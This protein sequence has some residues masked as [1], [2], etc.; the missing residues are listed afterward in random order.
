MV[1]VDDDAPEFTAS[2]AHDGIEPF[3]LSDALGDGP[4]VLAFFPA[5]FSNTCTT[6]MCTFRDRLARF[7][8][9]GGTV[10]GVS[11]DLPHAQEAYR[12]KH[13]LPFGLVADAD[14]NAIEA[15]DVADDGF[16]HYGIETVAQRSVF[17]VDGDGV[18]VYRWLA[19]NPG[20]EPD[21]DEVAA[22][23]DEA[24]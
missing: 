8:E 5:A 21:Y 24:V 12:T 20:Q 18:V 15:Y 16:T 2:L 4:V 13:D 23:V 10:F 19:D 7:E 11:T 9:V 14:H 6:E 17:V 22:A 1:D 3:R